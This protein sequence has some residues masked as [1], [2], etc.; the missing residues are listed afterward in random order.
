M[1]GLA[2]AS[3][4]CGGAPLAR[5]LAPLPPPRAATV[6]EVKAAFDEHCRGLESLSAQGDLEVRDARSGKAQRIGVR[7]VA[8]RG[9]RL[10]LKGSVAVVTALEVVA[11]GERFW[12]QVPSKKTVWTG[13]SS[14]APA[15]DA[16]SAEQAPYYALRPADVTRA[17]LPEPLGEEGGDLVLL[18]AERQSFSL[19]VGR[20]AGPGPARRRVWLDRES[21]R[22]LRL[23]EFDERGDVSA[24]VTYSDYRD[25]FPREVVISRPAEGY[26]AAFSLDRAEP[27]AKVPERAFVPRSPEGYKVIE[28]Q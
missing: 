6:E 8:A 23:R 17:L 14:A 13:I 22:P 25:G 12:L 1:A 19:L 2:L 16:E 27:N 5:P 9:G 3:C 24:E 15:R 10:Y 20:G 11:N 4:A 26:V 18:E 7:L 28:V 21:L